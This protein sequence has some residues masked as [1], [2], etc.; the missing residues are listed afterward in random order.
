MSSPLRDSYHTILIGGIKFG[1]LV[2]SIVERYS[3]QCP[4]IGESSERSLY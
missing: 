3:I 1:N 2:L 4:F